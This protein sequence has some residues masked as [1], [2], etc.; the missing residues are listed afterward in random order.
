MLKHWPLLPSRHYFSTKCAF[1]E[2]SWQRTMLKLKT[3]SMTTVTTLSIMVAIMMSMTATTQ[4]LT[5][6]RWRVRPVMRGSGK[7]ENASMEVDERQQSFSDTCQCECC[8][9]VG[10]HSE[11]VSPTYTTFDVPTCTNCNVATCARHFPISC[12]EPTS[13]V[14]TTCI[15]RKGWVVQLT[16]LIFLFFSAALLFY[17]CFIKKYDGYHPVP[18]R[19]SSSRRPPQGEYQS[20]TSSRNGVR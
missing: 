16:P 8:Y 9:Q 6:R 5:I 2:E 17:G 15:V 12:D 10:Q 14:N 18:P 1:F 7:S 3:W 13:E 20:T 19:P 4:A 11:C